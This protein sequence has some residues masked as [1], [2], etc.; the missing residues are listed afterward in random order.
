M[1]SGKRKSDAEMQLSYPCSVFWYKAVKLKFLLNPTLSIWQVVS[2]IQLAMNNS[3]DC[4]FGTIT[5]AA[6]YRVDDAIIV[7]AACLVLT[8]YSFILVALYRVARQNAT[9]IL[10][11]SHGACDCLLLSANTHRYVNAF[12]GPRHFDCNCHYSH[13]P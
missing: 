13:Y 12:L 7:I 10:F 3:S 11:L 8:L 2:P 5:Q 4:T 6:S 1:C 9:F